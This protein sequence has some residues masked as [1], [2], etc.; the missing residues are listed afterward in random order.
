MNQP[1]FQTNHMKTGVHSILK[2]YQKTM[3]NTILDNKSTTATNESPEDGSRANYRN[4][5]HIKY[6]SDSGQ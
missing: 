1:L 6:T 3:S 4:V 5:V 2:Q